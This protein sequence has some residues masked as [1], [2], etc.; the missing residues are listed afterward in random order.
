MT[1]YP[2][3]AGPR[4]R[5]QSQSGEHERLRVPSTT[6]DV[7]EYRADDEASRYGDLLGASPVMRELFAQL[8]RLEGSKV[9]L[10]VSGESGTGKELIARAVHEHSLVRAGPFVALNCGALDRQL[11]RSELFGHERGAFTGAIRTRRGAFEAADC[12]TL[13]LDEIGE[14]PSEVQPLLLRALEQRKITPVGSH[15]ERPVDVRLITATN[16]DLAARVRSGNF[17]E[18]LYY[19][20][21]VVHVVVPPLRQRP[22][23]AVVLA[24]DFA[25]RL[26]VSALPAQVLETLE[27]RQWPGNVRELRNAVEA[28]VALG[29]LPQAAASGEIEAEIALESFIDPTKTYAEQKNELVQRFTRSYLERL[30][31]QTGGNQSEAA[32][33]SGLERSYLGRLIDKLRLRAQP[34]VDALSQGRSVR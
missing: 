33:I 22:G 28:Y 2:G 24:Q 10:L 32:R 7:L 23:D 19:R 26:G 29:V 34:E 6:H 13:F 12:G 9:N 18:D 20:I 21:H 27:Q 8:L 11:A 3:T 16:R 31:R 15:E 5:G 1:T 4:K 25:A 17:R 14:L 30:L